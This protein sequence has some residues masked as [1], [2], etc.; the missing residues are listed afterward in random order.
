M[1]FR[2]EDHQAMMPMY[3]VKMTD[4]PGV[5]WAVPE[6]VREIPPEEFKIPVRNRR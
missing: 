6:L 2:A 4:K 5:A 1:W 3:H